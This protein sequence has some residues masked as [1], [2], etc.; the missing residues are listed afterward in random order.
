MHARSG[1]KHWVLVAAG[2]AAV[3]GGALGATS[4]TGAVV[5]SRQAGA[6]VPEVDL[7]KVQ[8]PMECGPFPVAVSLK[9][10][11]VV[12]GKALAVLAGHCQADMGTPPDQVFVVE[13]AGGRPVELLSDRDGYTLTELTIRSDGSIR[14]AARGYS[15]DDV[16]RFSPDVVVELVW[17]QSARGWTRAET[18]TPAHTA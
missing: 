15:S 3:V 12:D 18:R 14:G 7:S 11:A 13:G 16:P 1:L 8:L 17:K 2:C 5:T 10:A 6:V 4:A 9:A